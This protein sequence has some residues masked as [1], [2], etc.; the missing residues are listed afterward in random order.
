[1]IH[2]ST[3]ACRLQNKTVKPYHVVL[4]SLCLCTMA[5]CKIIY[6]SDSDNVEDRPKKL[7]MVPDKAP[8]VHV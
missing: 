6:E 7:R 1:M 2:L 5:K 8:Q 4:C 3:C